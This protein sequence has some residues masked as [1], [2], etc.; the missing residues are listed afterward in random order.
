MADKVDMTRKWN[1]PI[2]AGFLV[3]VGGLVSYEFFA[4]FPITR[5]FPWANLLLFGI[6]AVLLIV[7]LFRGLGRPQLYRGKIFGSIFSAIALFL[8][9]FFSYEIFYVLRQVPLSAHAPR[10]GEKAPEFT[11]VDKNGKPV[12]LANLLSGSRAAV[13]IFYRGFW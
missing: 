8:F 5:D 6:G 13:L 7:G 10:V 2:W 3:A 12:A 9:V 4:Q 1:W 11:L